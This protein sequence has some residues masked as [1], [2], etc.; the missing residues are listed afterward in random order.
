MKRYLLSLLIAITLLSLMGFTSMDN[1]AVGAIIG[2]IAGAVAGGLASFLFKDKKNEKYRGTFTTII[3]ISVF[4]STKNF[5]MPYYYAATF[6]SDLKQKYPMY[7]TIATYYPKDY[8]SFL[9]QA[10]DSVI[11]N[12]SL[13]NQINYSAALVNYV[14]GKSLPFAPAKE[15][16]NYLKTQYEIE[17]NLYN[18]N[19][20]LVLAL[21]APTR[22]PSQ[23]PLSSLLNTIPEKDINILMEA[24]AR[25]IESGSKD[26]TRIR[27]SD[28]EVERG[29]ESINQL[30]TTLKGKYGDEAVNDTFILTTPFKDPMQS[31]QITLS[32]YELILAK[33]EE[34]G[35]LLFKV[36]Y[37]LTDESKH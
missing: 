26:Q 28:A 23:Y 29:S 2:G 37:A 14:V 30:I 18:T 31:A 16:Y 32:F 11:N 22:I 10:K 27:L 33:G 7:S 15:V 17:K 12:D 19:P 8:S 34:D 25:I 21:E 35:A 1:R 36:L 20:I 24:K 3:V 5:L 13:N 6:D 4:F 9:A